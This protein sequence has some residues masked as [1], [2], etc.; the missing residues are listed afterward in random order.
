ME[1]HNR[2]FDDL[3]KRIYDEYNFRVN[4]TTGFKVLYIEF[5]KWLNPKELIY[6]SSGFQL[7]INNSMLSDEEL[8]L[9]LKPLIEAKIKK[10]E[11][12]LKS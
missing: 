3:E 9:L 12:C 2:W 7:Q 6:I 4:I 11:D 10:I 8:Y 5:H 1:W